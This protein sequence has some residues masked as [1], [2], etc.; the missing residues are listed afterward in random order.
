MLKLFLQRKCFHKFLF[1]IKDSYHYSSKKVNKT[2]NTFY[3]PKF[4]LKFED[5]SNCP[6]HINSEGQYFGR[7]LVNVFLKSSLPIVSY[8]LFY[9]CFGVSNELIHK[10]LTIGLLFLPIMQ[11]NKL[12][13]YFDIT[14]K[15]L[16]LDKNGKELIV[17]LDKGVFTGFNARNKEDLS[18]FE[19]YMQYTRKTSLYLRFKYEDIEKA[20]HYEKEKIVKLDIKLQKKIFE[21]RIDLAKHSSIIPLEYVMALAQGQ[22]IV[23]K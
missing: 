12:I 23:I 14:A 13:K 7:M 2:E 18:D 3:I 22:K 6:I 1:N 9:S 16:H 21:I 17:V 10:I 8:F 4:A 19:P 11:C 20:E 15:E 5:K